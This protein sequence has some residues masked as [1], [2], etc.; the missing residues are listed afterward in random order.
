[1]HGGLMYVGG[2]GYG[3]SSATSGICGLDLYFSSQRLT[4]GRMGWRAH[5]LQLRCLSE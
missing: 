3:W 5:G 2:D 1:M 4:T